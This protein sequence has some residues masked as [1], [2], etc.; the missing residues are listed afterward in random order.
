MVEGGEEEGLE[1]LVQQEERPEGVVEVRERVQVAGEGV[2]VVAAA[3]RRHD[4][5]PG[6]GPPGRPAGRRRGA[7]REA[8]P[9][10]PARARRPWRCRAG[11]VGGLGGGLGTR[12][13]GRWC[14]TRS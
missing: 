4:P 2:Q 7:P 14:R 5:G 11:R 9:R 10:G 3:A 8:Q 12:T 1:A 13:S 6:P